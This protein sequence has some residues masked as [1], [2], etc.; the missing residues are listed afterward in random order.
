[1]KLGSE[2]DKFVD[3]NSIKEEIEI[4]INKKCDEKQLE[5]IIKSI[6]F[7]LSYNYSSIINKYI[8]K[9][10]NEEEWM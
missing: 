4:K 5:R 3:L 8:E 1:M 2:V 6:G 7:D 9:I 10:N